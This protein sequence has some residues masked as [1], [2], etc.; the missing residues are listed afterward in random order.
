MCQHTITHRVHGFEDQVFQFV[1]DGIDAQP[2]GDGDVDFQRFLRDTAA[3]VRAQ[4]TQR[5]HVVQPVGQLDHDDADIFRHRQQ[6]FLDVFRLLLDLVLEFD[7][8]EFADAID[9]MRNVFAELTLDQFSCC[10]CVFQHIM[11]DGG[12][13]AFHIHMHLRQNAR[14][15]NG[16]IN[17]RFAGDA[18]LAFV[19]LC[20][21]QIS[22]ID[23]FH[24]FL[25]HVLRDQVA[26]IR[27]QET[28][29]HLVIIILSGRFAHW[30][31]LIVM[32]VAPKTMGA[33]N[34]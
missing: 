3:L 33:S 17:V 10:R 13:D 18:Q 16:V 30:L 12:D 27:D 23:F 31:N 28:F 2:V 4:R 22:A 19:R 5:T 34:T 20:A 1:A 7:V 11:Q 26:Q 8:G 24:L 25:I 9:Q 6:H 29:F 32:S 15:S 14:H 21:K